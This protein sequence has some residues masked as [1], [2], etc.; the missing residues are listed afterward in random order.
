MFGEDT[1]LSVLS[2]CFVDNS[3]AVLARLILSQYVTACCPLNPFLAARL[4][5][6]SLLLGGGRASFD[7]GERRHL[8]LVGE[9]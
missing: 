4:G 8:R 7:A 5:D 2:P 3:L 6:R 1:G 9:H